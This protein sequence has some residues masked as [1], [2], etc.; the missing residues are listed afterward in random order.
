MIKRAKQFTVFLPNK[1]GVAAKFLG[2]LGRTNVTAVSVLDSIDGCTVR[3]V[4]SNATQAARLLS[5]A[6][7]CCTTQDVLVVD[8]PNLPGVLKKICG[9]LGRA[10]VNIDYM[11]GSAGAKA[12]EAPVVLRVSSIPKAMA[13]LKK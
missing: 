6:K 9:K 13:A 10:R 2:T 4:A 5:K 7:V 3:L 8:M 11:Y 12:S 1:P